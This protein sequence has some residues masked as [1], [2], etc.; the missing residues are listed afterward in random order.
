ML[1]DPKTGRKI[2]PNLD[3]GARHY[4]LMLDEGSGLHHAA[5]LQP[6]N[7][8]E[9]EHKA[10]QITVPF[11]ET[12]AVSTWHSDG[13]NHQQGH[14]KTGQCYVVP[15]EQPHGLTIDQVGELV[16]FYITPTFI[17][18]A[19]PEA[20]QPRSLD[21]GNLQISEDF[22]IRQLAETVRLD[23]LLHGVANKLLVESA[24]NVLAFHLVNR[25]AT[26]AIKLINPGELSTCCLAKVKE[27]IAAES[28]RDITIADIAQVAGYSVVHFTRMFK[29]TTGQTPYQ[30]LL[31]Y[32]IDHAKKLLRTTALPISDIAYTVGFG[33][34]AHFST[35]FRQLTSMSPQAYRACTQLN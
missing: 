8:G 26:T 6:D 11:G 18:T 16:N 35:Q 1:I 17:A 14:V 15:S 27:F 2:L 34:H 22:F 9:H 23:R 29:R 31:S 19:L 33:S 5:N 13:G 12:V 25:Y 30:Y 24:T 7:F 10:Y 21:L 20:T 32:R 4:H 28:T 3:R